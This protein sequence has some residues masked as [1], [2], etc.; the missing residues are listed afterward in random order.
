MI[1]DKTASRSSQVAVHTR[2]CDGCCFDSFPDIRWM[3]SNLAVADA[4]PEALGYVTNRLLTC[5]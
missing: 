4:A 2:Y 5:N 3:L 1:G